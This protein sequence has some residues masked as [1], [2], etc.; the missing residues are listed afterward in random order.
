MDSKTLIKQV[1]ECRTDGWKHSDLSVN[2]EV[3]LEKM[4]EH[5][6]H[7]KSCREEFDAQSYESETLIEFERDYLYNTHVSD[8]ICEEYQ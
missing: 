8:W 4:A 6:E 1:N 7:C 5:Y 2:S 3:I